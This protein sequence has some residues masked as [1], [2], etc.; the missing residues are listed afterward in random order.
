MVL[1][2]GFGLPGAHAQN[3]SISSARDC[4]ANAVVF[5]GAGSVSQ[6]IN[7]FDNG[8]GRN[9]AASIHNIFSFFGV[10]AADVHSMANAGV[11][12]RAGNVTSSGQV[13]D[14][15]GRMVATSA[16]TGGRQNIGSSTREN[17]G[18]T[19]FFVRPP[20]VSFAS[21]PI[22]AFVVMQNGRFQFAILASS[23]TEADT[24]RAGT[25]A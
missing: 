4:D 17:V 20:S 21:S 24:A 13:F 12:V 7:K 10:S 8:D 18:G 3:V 15:S 2:I 5:C 14:G 6:L 11:D 23:G 25:Q 22:H 9:S 19:V 16:M 1:A